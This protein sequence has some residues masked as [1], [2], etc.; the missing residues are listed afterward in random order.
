M[1]KQILNEEDAAKYLTLINKQT[2]ANWRCN[3]KGPAY[4][5]IGGR[6]IYRLSDLDNYISINRIDTEKD[7]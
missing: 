4:S 1:E 5:K 3:K 6:I 7:A 2:L